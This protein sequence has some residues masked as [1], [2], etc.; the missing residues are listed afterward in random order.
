MNIEIEKLQKLISHIPFPSTIILNTKKTAKHWFLTYNYFVIREDF[1]FDDI[2]FETVFNKKVSGVFKSYVENA[3]FES[4]VEN[5]KNIGFEIGKIEVIAW[6]SEIVEKD[7]SLFYIYDNQGDYKGL[8]CHSL[9][10]TK[11]VV[12][13][14]HGLSEFF[15]LE[16]EIIELEKCDLNYLLPRKKL[17]KVKKQTFEELLSKDEYLI[18]DAEIGCNPD[19]EFYKKYIDSTIIPLTQNKL[20]YKNLNFVSDSNGKLEFF[21]EFDTIRVEFSLENGTDYLDE[22]F[23]KRLNELLVHSKSSKLFILFRHHNFGQEYGLAY[24]DNKK[25][26]KLGDLFNIELI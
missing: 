9:N 10:W 5:W 8:Y 18:L 17:S 16:K 14:G 24:L 1:T 19:F 23:Y 15:N 13:L 20:K 22:E 21:W 3:I 2:P 26:K 25:A 6:C 7:S 4:I 11:D 12:Y